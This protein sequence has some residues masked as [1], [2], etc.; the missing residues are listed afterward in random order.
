MSK[1]K[2]TKAQ[3]VPAAKPGSI[4]FYFDKF[5]A[6]HQDPTNILLHIIF[7][8]LLFFS[9]FGLLWAIPFPYIKFLGRYNADFNWS[10][11]LL[12]ISVYYY[13]RLSPLL[14]YFMLF[15]MLAYSYLVILLLQ[16]QKAG[17]PPMGALCG[18][19]FFVSCAALYGG[20][21]K[22]SKKLSF[23]YQCKNILIAPLFLVHLVVKRFK[24]KY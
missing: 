17:G 16:W 12:A 19:I 21:K 9:L 23:E 8:P 3:P 22:E 7:I 4:A 2:T 10:S 6:A 15:I 5:A 11:F 1:K 13:Y 20:Y 14:S 24:I 18:L